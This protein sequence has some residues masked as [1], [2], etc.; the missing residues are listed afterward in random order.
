[1]KG[2]SFDIGWLEASAM[3]PR[4]NQKTAEGWDALKAGAWEEAKTAFDSL[5]A[6]GDKPAALDG[7][8]RARWWLSFVLWLAAFWP[9]YFTGASRSS[10]SR[11]SARCLS[12]SSGL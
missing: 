1:M 9:A 3:I 10:G 2:C 11:F 5:A 12:R 6:D 8:G 7:L 4:L